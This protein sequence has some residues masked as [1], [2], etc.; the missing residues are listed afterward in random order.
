MLI[1]IAILIAVMIVL[2]VLLLK[3]S[4]V[5]KAIIQ[6]C[7]LCMLVLCG[8]NTNSVHK[9][10]KE[11]EESFSYGVD[12]QIFTLSKKGKNVIVLMLDRAIGGYIPYIF[13]ECPEIAEEFSGFIPY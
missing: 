5:A 8:I 9:Q 13:D 10:M 7:I 4:K 12:G 2:G 11:L 6:I 3:L 1:N